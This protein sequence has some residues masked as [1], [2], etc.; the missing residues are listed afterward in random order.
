[1]KSKDPSDL[2]TRLRRLGFRCPKEAIDELIARSVRTRLS[3]LETLEELTVLESRERDARNL[4][5]RVSTA[6][7]G[8]FKTLDEFDWNH[9]KEI[10][11]AQIEELLSLDF[12]RNAHNI[13]F[14]G[15]AGLGK[16]TLSQNLGLRAL[17][18]GFTVRFST[19]SAAL[20]DLLRQESVPATER[21]LKRYTSPDLLILDELGY[22][23]CDTRA[24]ELLYHVVSRR[25]EA[26]SIII[27]TNLPFKQWGSVFQDA[28]CLISLVDRFA[29]HAHICDIT[30]ESWRQTKGRNPKRPRPADRSPE[31]AT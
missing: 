10:D 27:T 1:M 2:Y 24:A 30:G 17:E 25:H 5:K 26:K 11:R 29:Q 14:R 28:A 31:S 15:P 20:A 12:L 18:A 22:V 21:R 23:P 4:K 16:T 7:L 8:K 9:P 19:L 3:S 6:A 13:L